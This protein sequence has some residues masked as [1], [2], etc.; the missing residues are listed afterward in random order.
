MR[1]INPKLLTDLEIFERIIPSLDKT[2]TL[3]GQT[4][5]R[6]LFGTLFYNPQNLLRR[7]Q[8]L[9]TLLIDKKNKNFRTRHFL[10]F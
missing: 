9:E 6:E 10:A 3:Y 4:K 5:F 2:Q 1:D 7:R 8:I